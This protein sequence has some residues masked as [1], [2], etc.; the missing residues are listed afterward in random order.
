[1]SNVFIYP[2]FS[3]HMSDADIIV[4]YCSVKVL[5][6]ASSRL[7]ER[8][9]H[10]IDIWQHENDVVGGIKTRIL[11]KFNNELELFEDQ[12]KKIEGKACWYSFVHLYRGHFTIGGQN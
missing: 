12:I 4:N 6:E 8:L 7:T 2:I 10:V 3:L 5:A 1:M 9:A 11:K